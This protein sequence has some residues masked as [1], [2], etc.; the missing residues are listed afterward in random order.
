MRN[1]QT[2]R[3]SLVT[4]MLALLVRTPWHGPAMLVVLA[5][6]LAIAQPVRAATGIA[7]LPIEV[8]QELLGTELNTRIQSNDHAGVLEVAKQIR[9]LD[10]AIPDSLLFV[11]ARA[12]FQMGRALEARDR[13]VAYL[14]RTGRSG[15]FYDAAT[16]LLIDV[17]EPAAEEERERAIEKQRR[18]AELAE[19]RAKANLLRARET[20]NLLH[21]LGFRLSRD[22]GTLDQATREAIAVFQ[23]RRNLTVN[24]EVTDELLTQLR[25]ETP[26]DHRCDA[27]AFAPKS[28]LDPEP[29]LSAINPATAV[30]ACN[31]ALRESPDLIRFQIQYA[32]ALLAA[33]KGRDA[34]SAARAAANKGYPRAITLLGEIYET[35]QL[36]ERGKPDYDRALAAYQLAAEQDYPEAQRRIGYYYEKGHSVTRSNTSAFEWYLAAANQGYAPAMVTV[37]RWLTA[38]KGAKRNYDNALVW[39]KRAAEG[40]SGEANYAI[41]EMYERGRGVKRNKGEA[42]VWYDKAERLGYSNETAQRRR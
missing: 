31:I 13:L 19:A 32:R 5:L 21:Q 23:V 24:A 12:L 41:G 9:G 11:E 25:R 39:L 35:G 7:G 20:Q 1:E 14:G 37:G 29:P 15:R 18:D 6:L 17:K 28:A 3:E 40:G 10:S 26:R 22:D 30:D 2:Y 4:P 42:K 8:Q 33:D 38:G 27:L 16:A 34:L 36:D